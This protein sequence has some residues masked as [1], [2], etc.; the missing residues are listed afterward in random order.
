VRGVADEPA[1]FFGCRVPMEKF[2]ISFSTSRTK[3]VLPPVGENTIVNFGHIK[4]PK[5][6][7]L[8]GFPADLGHNQKG[9]LDTVVTIATPSF[10]LL[11]KPR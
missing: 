4:T 10:G 5:Q 6:K 8:S 11:R 3:C 7:D 1:E 9:V 2:R